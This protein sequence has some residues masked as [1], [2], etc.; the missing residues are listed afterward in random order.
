MINNQDYSR[1]SVLDIVPV[2]AIH[3]LPAPPPM[4]QR[5]RR[6]RPV[7]HLRREA[8]IHPHIRRRLQF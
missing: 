8:L 7:N 6:A 1:L 3:A 5:I 2:A 4:L